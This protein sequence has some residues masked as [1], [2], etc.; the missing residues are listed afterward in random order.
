M[1]KLGVYDRMKPKLVM[2]ANITQTYQFV[3]TGAAEVGFVA[4][5]QVIM[6]QGGSRW[7]VPAADHTPID[8]QAIL[9]YPGLN[10]AAAKA[11]MTY[12]KSP[13]ATRIIKRYGY[14]VR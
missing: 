2:G 3:A 7:V 13:K 11:F 8:Q 1:R 6:D 5:S 14:E 12:L 10:S 4:L 9:L